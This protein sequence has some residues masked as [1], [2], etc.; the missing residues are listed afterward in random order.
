VP[1]QL[2]QRRHIE[3]HVLC[4]GLAHGALHDGLDVEALR[5]AAHTVRHEGADN[6][7]RDETARIGMREL[8]N[9]NRIA[10]RRARVGEAQGTDDTR[11]HHGAVCRV[12]PAAALPLAAR[13]ARR[14]TFVAERTDDGGEGHA[15]VERQTICGHEF[16]EG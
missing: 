9:G 14:I 13:D 12:A 5:L 6:G 8:G 10:Y 11:A 3:L 16:S 1:L 4:L 2:L 7:A 15:V